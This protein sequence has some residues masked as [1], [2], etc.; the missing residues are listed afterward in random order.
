MLLAIRSSLALPR[1]AQPEITLVP[2]GAFGQVGHLLAPL[3]PRMAGPD[4]ACFFSQHV[5]Q[6]R[7]VVRTWARVVGELVCTIQILRSYFAR[8]LTDT[9]PCS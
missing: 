7:G 4:Q 6:A 1:R 9:P 8:D 3:D 2:V 5:C